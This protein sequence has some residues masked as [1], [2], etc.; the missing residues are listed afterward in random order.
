ML[1]VTTVQLA[2]NASTSATSRSSEDAFGD[3]VRRRLRGTYGYLAAGLAGTAAGAALM[4]RSGIAYRLMS[5][6]PI[7]VGIG[8]LAGLMGT[9]WLTQS[10]NYHESPMAKH[11]AF[12]G[13]VGMQSLMMAP[14]TVLGGPLL[15]RA[16]IATGSIVGAISL[17]A[18]TAPSQSYLSLTGPLNIG[19]G[20]MFGASLGSLFFPGA[21]FL[22]SIVLY[23]GLALHGGLIFARTQALIDQAER[24]PTALYDPINDCLGI[25]IDSLAI[26]WRMAMIM[27]GGS[28]RKK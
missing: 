2:T 15:L 20:L 5:M 10:I 28:S 13:F 22:Y 12:A 9:M 14:L 17:T 27:S 11:L 25:Y 18:A 4:F 21:G 26:F 16:A 19:M 3:P 1:A 6:N 24:R 23:G 8:S 7:V